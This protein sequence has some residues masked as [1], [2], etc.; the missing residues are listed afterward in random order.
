LARGAQSLFFV[1]FVPFV[2]F[3]SFVVHRA[4]RLLLREAAQGVIR[5]SAARVLR[6]WKSRQSHF[7]EEEIHA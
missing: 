5:F 7:Q 6:L 3:S 2:P 4:A 1:P